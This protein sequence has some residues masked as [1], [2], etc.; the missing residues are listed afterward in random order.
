MAVHATPQQTNVD[1]K[2][3]VLET[4]LLIAQLLRVG[5][6]ISFAVIAVGIIATLLTGQTGYQEVRLDDLNSLVGYHGGHPDF[7]DSFGAILTGLL[8]AKPYAIIALGLVILIAIPILRVAVSVIA[9]V[10]ERDWT[11]VL[12]T[13]FVLA[14]LILGLI[15]GEIEGGPPV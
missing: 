7:P 3:A 6:I 1:H 12:I 4:E 15:L 2:P 9:F 5:V 13:A 10:R 14:M 11:Y 8:A